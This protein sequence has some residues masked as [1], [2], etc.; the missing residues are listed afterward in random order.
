MYCVYHVVPILVFDV[1]VSVI[2]KTWWEY[3][4]NQPMDYAENPG[5]TMSK[6]LV[7]NCCLNIVAYTK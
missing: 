2:D 5:L 7:N 6:T 3:E 4:H 1:A